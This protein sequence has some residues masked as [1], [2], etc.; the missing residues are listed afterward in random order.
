MTGL[1]RIGLSL[2]LTATM[3]A[4]N[5]PPA[6][7]PEVRKAIADGNIAWGKARVSLDTK[8]FEQYLAPDF[9]VQLNARKITRQEFIDH[10][11]KLPP[12]VTLTRFDAFPLTIEQ[13]D[14]TWVAIIEEKLEATRKMDD[15]KTLKSYTLSMTRDGWKKTSEGKWIILYSE[16]V[17]VERWRGDPPPIPEW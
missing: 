7:P 6:T 5:P 9:Y 2:F 11:S 1:R 17:G 10:I 3:V 13:K 16:Q 4:Q 8:T 14:D 15:G 12:G